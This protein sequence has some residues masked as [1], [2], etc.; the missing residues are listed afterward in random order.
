M[1]KITRKRQPTKAED[2]ATLRKRFDT[3]AMFR[4]LRRARIA[5]RANKKRA[6]YGVR[7]APFYEVY[8]LKTGETLDIT[9]CGDRAEYTTRKAALAAAKDFEEF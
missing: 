4:Q 2:E 8:D 9:G 6:R 1:R 7:K 3:G 5:A